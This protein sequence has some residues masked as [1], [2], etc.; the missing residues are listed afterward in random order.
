MVTFPLIAA[1]GQVIFRLL[2]SA[3]AVFLILLVL[4]QRGRGGGLAGALGGMG[5][6]RM[7]KIAGRCTTNGIETEF[8]RFG[9]RNGND[10][11]FV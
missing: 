9:K 2:L 10:A 4:V 6:N 5:G 3:M 11:I 8:S 7:G 1:I